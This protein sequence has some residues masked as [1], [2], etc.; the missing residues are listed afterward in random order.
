V[1]PTRRRVLG[2]LG[3][4]LGCGLAGC[5]GDDD[6][7]PGLYATDAQVVYRRDDDRFDYPTD[8]GV[9]VTVENTS[10]DRQGATLRTTLDRLGQAGGTPA[11]V[12]SWMKTRDISLS[13]G[14]TRP[15]F[16]VFQ[17]AGSDG[18]PF[19]ARAVLD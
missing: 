19:E 11:V 5:G 4:G 1:T 12:D 17:G 15:Y 3:L 18:G 8:V 9:R 16:F 2:W 7:P 6:P 14:A 13:R 10:P